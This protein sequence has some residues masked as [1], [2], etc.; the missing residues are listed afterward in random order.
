MVGRGHLFN[1]SLWLNRAND[2]NNYL[3]SLVAVLDTLIEY[4]M[5]ELI[6]K[7]RKSLLFI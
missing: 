3:F 6:K 7:P 4:N 1:L 5:E 2:L